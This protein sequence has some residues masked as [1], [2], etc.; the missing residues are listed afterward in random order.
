MKCK[1]E[2][3]RIV[4]IKDRDETPVAVSALP[5]ASNP[6][7][8]IQPEDILNAAE[9]STDAGGVSYSD[10]VLDWSPDEFHERLS[11]HNFENIDDVERYYTE[12]YHF[13]SGN[14]GVLLFM[15]TVLV[16]KVRCWASFHRSYHILLTAVFGFRRN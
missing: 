1:D 11:L 4:Y 14:Y 15:Y 13:L 7:E 9:S 8:I 3:Y 12:N 16:T 10:A 5:S 6:D 2:R